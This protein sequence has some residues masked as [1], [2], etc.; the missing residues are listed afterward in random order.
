MNGLF[1][2]VNMRYDVGDLDVYKGTVPMGLTFTQFSIVKYLFERGTD[3]SREDIVEHCLHSISGPRTI[4]VHVTR[5]R[6]ILGKVIIPAYG[7]GYRINESLFMPKPRVT[8]KVKYYDG[9]NWL[10][11]SVFPE[12]KDFESL[13]RD[14]LGS[15]Q[16]GL[17]I[18][19]VTEKV[20]FKS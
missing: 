13:K 7:I 18:C 4:D 8:Y 14:V 6:K 15:E 2:E 1:I 17:I 11:C 20:I 9:E 10:P 5:I 19:K 12:S 16:T 3:T